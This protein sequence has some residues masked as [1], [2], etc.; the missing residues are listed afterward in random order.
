MTAE[1]KWVTMDE[2]AREA[3]VS[4]ITVSRVLRSPEKVS[5]ETRE[6][7]QAVI[8]AL[9]Y[10]LDETAGSLA[11]GE[12]RIVA[13][14]VSTLEGSVFASTIDGINHHLREHG[15]QLLL[16]NTGYSSASEATLIATTFGHRPD[17]II[18]TSSEHTMEAQALLRA[19]GTAV[20]EIWEL[21]EKPIDMAVGFSNAAAGHAMTRFLFDLGRRRIAFIGGG[22]T[23]DLR[24]RLRYDGYAAAMQ[25][26][27]LGGAPPVPY[28]R[29]I[30][31]AAERGARG[32][33]W[34]LK[35]RP[36][37]D[38]VFC[39]SDTVALGALHEA[40]RRG[41][42]VPGN[43]ALAG[44]GD[45]EFAGEY[46]LGLTTVRIPGYKIG[47]TAA[48]LVLERKRNGGAGPKVIDLGFEIVRRATA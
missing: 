7:V 45:F 41:K 17:G 16:G 19:N 28:D 32:M 23:A 44:L 13:A 1:L 4:K 35:N 21:P 3:K 20:V 47:Q 22:P 26:L 31:S 5:V 25:A 14:M 46:G 42:C 34:L 37:V 33:R 10:V 18:L 39:T 40:R 24:G 30:P 2:V 36:D 43:I 29:T 38:A 9:G 8:R 27:G 15:H 12:S 48:R 6:R 11:S